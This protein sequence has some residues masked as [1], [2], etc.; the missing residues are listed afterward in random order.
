MSGEGPIARALSGP[1][2]GEL[3]YHYPLESNTDG[4]PKFGDLRRIRAHVTDPTAADFDITALGQV[5]SIQ[6]FMYALKEDGFDED[7]RVWYDNGLTFEPYRLVEPQPDTV[8]SETLIRWTLVEDSR[9]QGDNGSGA[10]P[11]RN[12]G[13]GGTGDGPSAGFSF[14]QDYPS[15]GYPTDFDGS[16][17]VAGATAISTYEWDINGVAYTGK[18]VSHTFADA[19]TYPVSLT[20]TD[21]AG[22]SDTSTRD[23]DITDPFV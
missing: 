8:G 21:G 15:G 7:S 17:S 9:G 10:E 4:T 6:F 14:S 5:D 20:V 1:E 22:L 23:V 12:D 11:P 3:V 2:V 18:N 19:G 13:D 16:A